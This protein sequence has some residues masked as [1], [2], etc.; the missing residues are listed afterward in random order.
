[1]FKASSFIPVKFAGHQVP[2][3]CICV[4]MFG[5]QVRKYKMLIRLSGA[6]A[7]KGLSHDS[8]GQ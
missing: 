6:E 1:M 7:Q 4:D 5:I 3:Q 2:I 8:G